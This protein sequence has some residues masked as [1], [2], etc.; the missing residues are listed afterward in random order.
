MTTMHEP[1]TDT[2][3]R[4][5]EATIHA[6]QIWADS[7]KKFVGWLPTPH[8]KVPSAAEVVDHYFDFA[9]HVLETQRHFLMSLATV[10][11]GAAKEMEHAAK[12]ARDGMLDAAKDD[13]R[14]D[15]KDTKDDMRYPVKDGAR[16]K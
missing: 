8:A 2:I 7:Y 4:D 15:A 9:A 13:M 12:D 3:H 5:Q 11:H 16:K 14:Y 6:L 1:M 10:A